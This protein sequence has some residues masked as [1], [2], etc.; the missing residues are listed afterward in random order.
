MPTSVGYGKGIVLAMLEEIRLESPTLRVLDIGAGCGTYSDLF[1]KPSDHWTAVEIWTPYISKYNLQSK[2]DEICIADA[3]RAFPL[4]ADRMFDVCILGDVLEH[5]SYKDAVE[6]V[7]KCAAHS[8]N[9][10]AS[11]PLG[12]WPQEAVDNNPYE[13]HVETWTDDDV[14]LMLGPVAGGI[15]HNIGVYWFK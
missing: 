8:Y 2:Y 10:I 9:V 15:D 14:H 7:R 11:I 6:L 3:R 5:M 4:F 12:P 1:R 13:A